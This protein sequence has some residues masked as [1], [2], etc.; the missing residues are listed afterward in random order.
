MSGGNKNWHYD[1][2]VTEPMEV[3]QVEGV[4]HN[5]LNIGLEGILLVDFKFKAKDDAAKQ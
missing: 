1:L 4:I 5:L 2:V 3:F